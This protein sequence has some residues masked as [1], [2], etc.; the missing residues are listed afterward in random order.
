MVLVMRNSSFLLGVAFVALS[1]ARFILAVPPAPKTNRTLLAIG[2]SLCTGQLS[3]PPNEVFF[4]DEGYNAKLFEYLEKAEHFKTLLKICCPGESSEELLDGSANNPPDDASF[5]YGQT[6][7]RPSSQLETADQIVESGQVE[8]ISISIGAND[9]LPCVSGAADP[10]QC[11]LARVDQLVSNLKA[12]LDAIFEASGDKRPPVVAMTPYNPLLALSL[13]NVEQEQSLAALSQ[14]SLIVL[15]A[16]VTDKVYVPYGV[17]V[18]DAN[19]DVY[20]GR[21]SAIVDGIPQN[22]HNICEYTGMCNVDENGVYV[23]APPEE[24]DIHPT[25]EGYATLGDA[26]I[27]LIQKLQL[28]PQYFEKHPYKHSKS[29]KHHEKKAKKAKSAKGVKH[30]KS[31]PNVKHYDDYR[32]S[33]TSHNLRSRGPYGKAP[34]GYV[35]RKHPLVI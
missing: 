26:H 7:E 32:A 27:E 29:T 14:L 28:F 4:S 31:V 16:E 19:A 25:E 18:V 10:E 11:V 1:H 35:L 21:N 17:A 34:K 2:D 5:C 3:D 6:P 23:L 8:L 15:H 22:V 13:S 30:G 20:D 9:I 33:A 12:I 24:R